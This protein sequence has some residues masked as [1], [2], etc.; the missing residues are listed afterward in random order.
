MQLYRRLPS[1]PRWSSFENP[2]AAPGAGG[3]E[4]QGAKGHAYDRLLPG[5]TKP[6]LDL[7]GPGIVRRIWLTI[8]DRTP[9][10]LRGLR[11][12]MT[13]DGAA[14]PATDCPLGDFFGLALGRRTRFASALFEDPEGRSF[15]SYVPMPFWRQ[16]SITLTNETD[17][18]LNHLFYDVNATVGDDLADALYFHAYWHRERPNELGRDLEILPRV[19]GAGRFLGTNFGIV[20][21]PRY[22]GCWWG[23]GEV[24]VYLDGDGEL[25]TLVG[26]GAEDYLGSA[27]GLGTFAG[28]Y[29]GCL[30]CDREKGEYAGYRYHIP[31]PI[32][33]DRECRVTLQ[34]IGG[35]G[36][37]KV[38]EVAATG[39][40]VRMVSLSTPESFRGAFDHGLTLDDPAHDPAAWC[41]FYRC[42]DWSATAY[43]YLDRPETE[44]PELAPVEKR[45]AA[46]GDD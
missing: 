30:L 18:P 23:E 37:A 44:L 15:V 17:R 4:N 11:L 24:K 32:A 20:T 36:L 42:D 35:A 43:L 12:R 31:D 29:H 26:T 3:S 22:A 45:M 16:A 33:F 25:P 21:D 8:S 5:E 34:T 39:A 1:T 9:D 2:S 14:R 38:R 6:L 28:P 40:P 46:I 13:W 10:M 19:D 27:W 41:N 7:A